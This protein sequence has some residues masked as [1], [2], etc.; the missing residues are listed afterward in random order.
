MIKKIKLIIK[1]L[2]FYK[3]FSKD[4]NVLRLHIKIML[5]LNL[6]PKLNNTFDNNIVSLTTYSKRFSEIH[7]TLYSLFKQSILPDKIILTLDEDEFSYEKISNNKYL[8][9]FIK[10]GLEI[11]YTK[12][13]GSYKKFIPI[14]TKFP[15][16]NIIICDDDAFYK[17]NWFE[18]LI[19]ENK[20]YP[21]SIL[22]HC[23]Y[24]LKINNK[25]IVNYN[26]WLDSK[27]PCSNK[28]LVPIG[29][30][31]TLIRKSFF[32]NDFYNYE[33]ISKLAPNGD[34]LW[35][36]VQALLNNIEI[37]LINNFQ[38]YPQDLGDDR[39]WNKLYNTNSSL[40]NVK[41]NNLINYYPKIKN[42]LSID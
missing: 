34:D 1:T 5:K 23:A 41:L 13:Y 15:N 42:I 14:I 26:D 4:N 32:N 27:I 3:Q 9:I 6:I 18:S 39:N 24:I 22:C 16:S 31:G 10:K 11:N 12:N 35:I 7:F 8:K 25:K 2:F 30:G 36:Y 21:N 37:R 19:N 38:G 29:V 40:N 28:Y 20:K 17:S 33:L